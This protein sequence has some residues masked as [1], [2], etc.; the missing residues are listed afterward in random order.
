MQRCRQRGARLY[1]A[2]KQCAPE[3]NLSGK[4]RKE[5]NG[6]QCAVCLML[7][8]FCF[9]SSSFSSVCELTDW[10]TAAI[11]QVIWSPQSTAEPRLAFPFIRQ[12]LLVCLCRRHAPLRERGESVCTLA[13]ESRIIIKEERLQRRERS[14]NAKEKK[15]TES[16]TCVCSS[17]SPFYLIS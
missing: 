12:T 3:N 1:P 17:L 15:K 11:Q 2:A 7:S 16:C 6:C 4:K 13:T 14:V 5:K 9:F 8:D 10:L